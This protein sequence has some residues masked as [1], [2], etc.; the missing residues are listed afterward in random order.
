MF[1]LIFLEKFIKEAKE[2]GFENPDVYYCLKALNETGMVF[3]PGS[4]FG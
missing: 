2:N 1:K 4:G 3:V